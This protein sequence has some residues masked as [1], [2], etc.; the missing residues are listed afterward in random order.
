MCDKQ[1]IRNASAYGHV[2]VLQW[3][4]DSGL[5]LKYDEE[6]AFSASYGGH[7]GVLQRLKDTGLESKCDKI[8]LE[9]LPS[10]ATP[11]V[12]RQRIPLAPPPV[13]DCLG[14]T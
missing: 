14:R 2:H 3:W 11:M 5:S 4:K 8:A 7:T 10:I 6:A 9:E 13:P 1:A 12:E